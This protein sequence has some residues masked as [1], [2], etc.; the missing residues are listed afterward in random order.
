MARRF[1]VARHGGRHLTDHARASPEQRSTR[2][3]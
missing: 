2:Q 3:P 1:R